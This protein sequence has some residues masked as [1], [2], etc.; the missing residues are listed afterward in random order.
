MGGRGGIEQ[1]LASEAGLPFV[2][3]TSRK[4][5]KLASPDSLLTACALIKGFAEAAWK[6]RSFQPSLVIGTGGYASAAVLIAQVMRRGKTLIH[7]QNTV[8]GRTNLWLSRYASR[9]CVTFAGSESAFPPGRTV[10]TGLPIRRDL[11]DVPSRSDGR[12]SLGLDP[13]LFT[14]LVYG[15]SQGARSFND[16]VAKAVPLLRDMPVQVL[17]QTGPRHFDKVSEFKRTTG[18][19]RY[20][21]RSYFDDVRPVF[22]A[23]DLALT[24]CGASTLAE[25]TA[26]G[27][28]SILVPFPHAYANHQWHNGQFVADA[29]GGLMLEDADLNGEMLMKL[30]RRFASAPDELARM[31]TVSKSLGRPDA[32]REIADIAVSML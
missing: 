10:V 2:G 11:L 16:A 24:R 15:G 12:A 3:L 8:P 26:L 1:R 32:A 27:I 4:L 7:E 19:A 17:H 6:L 31:R 23:T 21:V 22:A 28:P 30:V 14:L 25:I 5:R 9:V 18:W 29:G 13:D 20:H